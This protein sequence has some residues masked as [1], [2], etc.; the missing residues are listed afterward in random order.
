MIVRTPAGKVTAF[1]YRERAP[2]GSTRTM[3][4]GNDGQIVRDLTNTGYLAPGVPGTVRGLELAHKRFRKLP[5]KT[6]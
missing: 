4:L 3:Y 5:G 2:L 6:W 1:D